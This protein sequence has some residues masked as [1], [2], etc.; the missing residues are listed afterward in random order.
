LI[1]K[2]RFVF[3]FLTIKAL[4][5]L[6]KFL[7]FDPAKRIT[8][9]EALKHP[10]LQELHCPEDEPIAKSVSKMEFEFEKYNLTL[11]QLKDLIYEEILLY[12]YPEFKK[13]YLSKINKGESVTQHVLKNDNSKVFDKSDDYE[14]Y[15]SDDDF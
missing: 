11:Q 10:F 7:I 8:L 6:R 3:L 15:P 5:L 12:H 2:F 14:E 13:D 9:D 4:D 1:L